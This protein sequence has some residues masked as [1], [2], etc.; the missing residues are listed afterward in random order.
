MFGL[1]CQIQAIYKQDSQLPG[2][3]C[4]YNP[5]TQCPTLKPSYHTLVDVKKHFHQSAASFK[6]KKKIHQP[7]ALQVPCLLYIL[8]NLSSLSSAQFPPCW[9]DEESLFEAQSW[10]FIFILINLTPTKCH[11]LNISLNMAI[12][13]HLNLN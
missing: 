13:L 8:V 3:D 12:I 11:K 5:N 6:N 9:L 4:S 2:N 10:K 1:F 7:N